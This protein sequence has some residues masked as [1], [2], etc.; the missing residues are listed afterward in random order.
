[1]LDGLDAVPWSTL[2]HAYGS[3][4]DLP[5]IL[6]AV[7]SG[8][9]EAVDALFGNIWHQGT[10]YEATAHAVPFLVELL[11]A[12]DADVA[13]LLALLRSIAQGHSYLEV[14]QRFEP[15]SQRDSPENAARLQRE[16]G[17]VRAAHDAVEQGVPAYVALLAHA[18][19]AV[20]VAA[21]RTLGTCTQSAP[22]A[23]PALCARVAAEPVPAVRAAFIL[24][25][26]TLGD[27]GMEQR[28]AGWMRDA[29]PGPRLAAAMASVFLDDK[30][31]PAALAV[32]EESAPAAMVEPD[33]FPDDEQDACSAALGVLGDDWEKQAALIASWTR[34][35]DGRVRE[36]AVFAS[37]ALLQRW[38]PATLPIVPALAQ[39]LDDPERDVRY[40]AAM[41]L[42]Y[43]GPLARPAADALWELFR[44]EPLEHNQPSAFALE[45]L[46]AQQ[47]PRVAAHLH[48][49]LERMAPPDRSG[50]RG[51][52]P[53]PSTTRVELPPG[54]AGALA[55]LGPWAAG[56]L[57]PLVR[58][59]PVVPSGNDRIAVM[60]AVG[61]YGDG[62]RS[63]V[64]QLR[65]ELQRHPHM[66]L[67]VLGNLGVHATAAAKDVERLLAHDDDTVK[68]RAARALWRITGETG[69]ALSVLREL[70]TQA[71]PQAL[72]ALAD[73]GPRA[74]SLKDLLPPLW[75][76]DD[77]WVSANSAVA[78]WCLTREAAPVLHLILERHVRCVPRCH[79]TVRCLG[80]M[81]AAASAAVPLLTQ[82]AT[83]AMRQVEVGATS[84]WISDDEAWKA[85]CTSALARITGN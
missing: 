22:A 5:G 48:V 50:W 71:R 64:S 46:C 60:E 75:N 3:A 52:L 76:S 33:G 17:W 78:W 54:L 65:A 45:A 41:T 70:V 31:T 36:S 58:L 77:D 68:A 35:A 34:H 44:R 28:L 7:A 81:G 26:S 20:R 10:V 15:R 4:A 69:P 74:A 18:E 29:A 9:R 83:A 16:Q 1:M 47:D 82:G 42:S 79:A 56:C 80:E 61:R 49:L 12:P 85:A 40:W 30:V 19:D 24:A 84:T 23:I 66:A 39:C 63:G 14:H 72:E 8:E 37:Q 27:D 62:A 38:R 51:L 13:G 43:C 55:H 6:R 57:W 21:A 53:A 2:T 73:M 59:I 25:V 32:L 67:R 11:G